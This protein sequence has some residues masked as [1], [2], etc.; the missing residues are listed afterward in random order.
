MAIDIDGLPEIKS[1]AELDRPSEYAKSK[2][3]EAI[4]TSLGSMEGG[5]AVGGTR[6]TGFQSFLN[7]NVE[8]M[9]V[10]GPILS[11]VLGTRAILATKDETQVRALQAYLTGTTLR[12]TGQPT[13]MTGTNLA[14]LANYANS[15]PPEQ[16]ERLMTAACADLMTKITDPQA[17]AA[18][19]AQCEKL[20][21]P[22]FL[23][24]FKVPI[25]LGVVAVGIAG[26]VFIIKRKEL[27]VGVEGVGVRV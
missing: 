11:Q 23:Q 26:I 9:K 14:Q 3:A 19:A 10:F 12:A 7:F 15:L 5:A 27:M 18:L 4:L 2:R 13:G 21:K 6:P 8:A 24:Q 17:R 25:I 1:M 22:P 16:R 20:K